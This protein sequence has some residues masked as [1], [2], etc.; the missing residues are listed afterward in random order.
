MCNAINDGICRGSDLN[1]K[2]GEMKRYVERHVLSYEN[3]NIMW[4]LECYVIISRL[5]SLLDGRDGD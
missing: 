5:L 1:R 2:V 3:V 4:I